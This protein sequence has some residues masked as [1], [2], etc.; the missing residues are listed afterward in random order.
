M[1]VWIAERKKRFPTAA[2]IASRKAAQD[3]AREEARVKREAEKKRRMEERDKAVQ[4]KRQE[5]HQTK[6]KDKT[7]VK[8]KHEEAG[9]TSAPD[10]TSTSA[11][12]TETPSDDPLARIAQLEEQLRQA[13]E[14]LLNPAKPVIPPEAKLEPQEPVVNPI[15]KEDPD[16]RTVD[17]LP[18][19]DAATIKPEDTTSG[20]ANHSLGIDYSSADGEDNQSISD[21]SS[22]EPSSESSDADS[23]DYD[24]DSDAPPEEESSKSQ[25]PVKREEASQDPTKAQQ[26]CFTFANTG[27][28]KYGKNC[29]RSHDVP[30]RFYAKNGYCRYGDKCRMSHDV[31]PGTGGKKKGASGGKG[32]TGEVKKKTMSLRERMVEKELEEEARTGLQVIKHL[33]ERGFF[34][35]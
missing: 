21:I 7:V 16:S 34:D 25:A 13:R 29:M 11:P 15:I 35:A 9:A 6:K 33:G 27:R 17:E 20:G 23:E 18:I 22:E 30:C 26:I 12:K 19:L 31:T 24:S 8:I 2:R 10:T 3:T 1:A 28:C 5:R 4:T 14:A 32:A